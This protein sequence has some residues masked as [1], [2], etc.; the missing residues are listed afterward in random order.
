MNLELIYEILVFSVLVAFILNLTNEK[1]E[2]RFKTIGYN[3]LT[4]A[5]L[6]LSVLNITE[7]TFVTSSSYSVYI[8]FVNLLV[9]VGYLIVFVF[10]RNYSAHYLILSIPINLMV[11]TINVVLKKTDYVLYSTIIGWVGGLIL[12]L[13]FNFYYTRVFNKSIIEIISKKTDNL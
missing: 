8:D 7:L 6:F 1:M 12:L 13:L 11:F 9:A 2:P 10:K 5:F 3:K 4:L